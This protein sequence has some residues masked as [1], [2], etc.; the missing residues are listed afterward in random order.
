MI[1]QDEKLVDKYL[2]NYK[3][4][5]IG[6]GSYGTVYKALNT[7]T[8][9]QVALKV[10]PKEKVEDQDQFLAEIYIMQKVQSPYVV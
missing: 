5:K 2:Y 1:A 7:Q 6:R 9:Q 10:I 3:T 4:A 8:K